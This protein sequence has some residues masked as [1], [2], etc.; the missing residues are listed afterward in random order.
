MATAEDTKKSIKSKIGKKTIIS[1]AIAEPSRQNPDNDNMADEP[2]DSGEAVANVITPQV[3]VK[4]KQ[5]IKKAAEPE[6]S[7]DTE[8]SD[9]EKAVETKVTAGRRVSKEGPQLYY[10]VHNGQLHSLYP[11]EFKSIQDDVVGGMVGRRT[12]KHN[13]T[14]VHRITGNQLRSNQERRPLY[15]V[16]DGKL[17]LTEIT[18]F[19]E[20]IATVK[21]ETVTKAVKAGGP[22]IIYVDDSRG[23]LYS[24]NAAQWEEVQQDL[25]KL[26]IQKVLKHLPT[27]VKEDKEGFLFSNDE[28]RPMYRV[29]A[30]ANEEKN[31]APVSVTKVDFPEAAQIEATS[32][33]DVEATQAEQAVTE[34]A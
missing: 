28:N 6:A 33:M 19:Q 27:C 3:P 17:V 1:T 23:P 8:Q 5:V 16:E 22:S 12:L 9:E 30:Y 21:G 32:E 10:V 34:E 13:P 20:K 4:Q 24:M 25:S 11:D 31:A 29:T 14:N 2:A 18:P 7:T 26:A 15:Y